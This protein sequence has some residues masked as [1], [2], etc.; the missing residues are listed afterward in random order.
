LGA[1]HGAALHVEYVNF[2]C[3]GG[4]AR[5]EQ[6]AAGEVHGKIAVACELSDGF[7]GILLDRVFDCSI[8]LGGILYCGVL[9]G[10]ILR[11]FKCLE[12]YQDTVECWLWFQIVVINEP[13]LPIQAAKPAPFV[14]YAPNQ[15]SVCIRFF[16]DDVQVLTECLSLAFEVVFADIDTAL[17]SDIEFSN[18]QL[19]VQFRK[20]LCK[21]AEAIRR[22]D[23]V[24]VG[25]GVF[26]VGLG[27]H[28][29]D[30]NAVLDP[31]FHL[32]QQEACFGLR[33]DTLFEVVIVV[34]EFRIRV[35]FVSP[36][37]C[38]VD[39]FRT[40]T[41]V[42]NRLGAPLWLVVADGF[43]HHVPF[44]NLAFPVPNY[45]L[46]MVLENSEKFVFLAAVF[47]VHPARDL[48]VPGECMATNAHAV[49]LGVLDHFVAIVVIELA[50]IRLGGVELHLVFG[51]DDVE[52]LLVN[53]FVIAWKAA[54]EPLRV[55][56]CA[57][58]DSVF[59]C[60]G[61]KCFVCG[62]GI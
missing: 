54:A 53:L 29:V 23:K 21:G 32:F 39:E 26:H 43:V 56:N 60:K 48:T 50:F 52:L 5:D 13:F 9:L 20:F 58:V 59:I 33:I 12:S 19:D 16:E 10:C 46:D 11:R 17:E 24:L 2:S 3:L 40:D 61:S 8:F 4:C 45:F 31:A 14:R 15:V 6:R 28:A 57:D 25:G 37:E 36:H 35:D 7:D 27:T 30:R 34:A 22:T 55:Q 51:N 41:L 1:E 49:C 44:V 18:F 42:P 38:R 62:E 47:L